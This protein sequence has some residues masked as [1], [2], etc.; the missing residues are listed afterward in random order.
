V[1]RSRRVGSA[2]NVASHKTTTAVIDGDSSRQWFVASALM[3]RIHPKMSRRGA[4]AAAY[5]WPRLKVFLL[6]F[7]APGEGSPYMR[8]SAV[9]HRQRAT[10][11]PRVRTA[12]VYPAWVQYDLCAKACD[13][14]AQRCQRSENRLES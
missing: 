3:A 7:G 10:F 14:D 13:G 1:R 11:P 4:M 9:R 2:L 8:K 6:F 12:R 5:R